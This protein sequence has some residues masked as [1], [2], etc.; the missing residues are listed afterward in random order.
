VDVVTYIPLP[1]LEE[2]GQKKVWTDD[3]NV[4]ELLKQ[5]LL[6]LTEIKLHLKIVTDEEINEGDL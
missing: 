4:G 2:G 3:Q 1:Q 6:E 5:I